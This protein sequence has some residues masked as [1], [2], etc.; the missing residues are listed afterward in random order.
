MQRRAGKVVDNSIRFADVKL[1]GNSGSGG[2]PEWLKSLLK[3]AP[4]SVEAPSTNDL[5][6]QTGVYGALMAW[7][8]VNGV[9]YS[10][11]GQFSSGGADVPG[12]ILA[13]GF[14]ASLYFLRKKN[15][16]L[17]ENYSYVLYFLIFF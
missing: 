7:T 1:L 4:V 9:Q 14:G 16:K 6:I 2:M 5:G 17:G 3:N 15:V 8:L 12:L 10:S 11:G 13:T